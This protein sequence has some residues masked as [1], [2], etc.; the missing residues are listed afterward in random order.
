MVLRK[1]GLYVAGLLLGAA[2]FDG[3][4]AYSLAATADDCAPAAKPFKIARKYSVKAGYVPLT[5]KL[6]KRVK[7]K[8]KRKPKIEC[9]PLVAP[10]ASDAA[11]EKL[12]ALDFVKVPT[13]PA[14]ATVTEP[15]AVKAAPEFTP[16]KPPERVDDWRPAYSYWPI[17]Y[18]APQWFDSFYHLRAGVARAEVI[19][20][21][22]SVTLSAEVR[23]PPA[24]AMLLLG[25]PL[26]AGLAAYRRR[27]TV[28][29]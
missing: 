9:L 11:L 7:K 17:G 18:G 13:A 25:I 22:V 4:V 10:G 6:L 2:L 20:V 5:T 29:A 21:P 12:D 1:L 28:V 3:S 24:W 19:S 26:A 23:E 27:R 15:V 8:S 14:L 16:T